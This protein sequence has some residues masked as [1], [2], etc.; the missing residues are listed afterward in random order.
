LQIVWVNDINGVINN[1]QHIGVASWLLSVDGTHCRVREPR[2]QPDKNWYS[3][4]HQKPCVAY[5]LG[6]HLT[7]SKLVWINGPFKAGDS[8][9]VIFRKPDGLKS[10]IPDNKLVIG[11]KGYCGEGVV[12]TPNPRD[13]AEVNQC[14][15]RARA[16]HET[17]NGKIKNFSILSE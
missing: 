12:S 1:N 4:K 17:F 5:E 8:D 11:D 2:S 15:R 3:H 13:N 7:E 10:K 6:V 14:K 16:R 9:L